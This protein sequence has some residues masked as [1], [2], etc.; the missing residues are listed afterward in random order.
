[1]QRW[2]PGTDWQLL[3]GLIRQES[4]FNPQAESPVGAA[5]L[6]QF[7]PGTWADVA[8][9]LN[10]TYA[11]RYMAGP[12]IEAG[13]YYLAQLR[14]G[15]HSPRPE[16]DRLQLALASYNAGMGHLIK[17]QKACGM[18]VLYPEIARCLPQITGHHAAETLHYVPTVWMYYQSKLFDLRL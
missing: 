11:N 1:M 7:M 14:R 16:A 18:P 5:G 15:W 6:T 8:G 17:A 9:R 2:M 4:A 13:A 12:S 10:L 3:W